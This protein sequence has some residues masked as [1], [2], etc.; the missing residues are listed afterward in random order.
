MVKISQLAVH[1]NQL[2]LELGNLIVRQMS[3]ASLRRQTVQALV[4]DQRQSNGRTMHQLSASVDCITRVHPSTA[5]FLFRIFSSSH[6]PFLLSP[7]PLPQS[8]PLHQS[9]PC[10]PFRLESLAHTRQLLQLG[11]LLTVLMTMQLQRH[12]STNVQLHN[13]TTVQLY[14]TTTVYNSQM[15]LANSVTAN[16]GAR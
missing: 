16:G 1:S 10:P 4:N 12:K 9:G 6:L 7:C 5:F 13:C 14:D 2:H 8:S 3:L 15:L 11:L